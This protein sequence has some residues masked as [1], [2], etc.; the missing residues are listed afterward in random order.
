MM[1]IELKF[2]NW[3]SHSGL[4]PGILGPFIL[5]THKNSYFSA[6]DTASNVL[7]ARSEKPISRVLRIFPKTL[8]TNFL[9]RNFVRR[10]VIKK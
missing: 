2:K 10:N 4:K 8:H 9:P 3:S 1:H 7:I 5:I 6:F